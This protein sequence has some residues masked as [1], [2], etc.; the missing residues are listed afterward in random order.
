LLAEGSLRAAKKIGKGAEEAAI[1]VKGFELPMH[2]PRSF[3]SWAVSYPTVPRGGC[4]IAAPTYWLERGVTFPDLVFPEQM[5]SISTDDKGKWTA[6]FQDFCEVLESMVTCKLSI[7]GGIRSNHIVDMISLCTGWDVD[8]KEILQ[9]G[10]RANNIKRLINLKLGFGKKDDTLPE[11][12]RSLSLKEGGTGGYIPDRDMDGMLA[13]YYHF[14][15]WSKDGVPTR[16]KF[17]ELG[18]SDAL[19]GD[20]REFR[21]Y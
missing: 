12:V 15:G 17:D 3:N 13:D 4:H 8:L 20:Y 16:E 1:Q 19:S 7:Y 18:L 14:R 11:R 9:I 10:E 5:D 2:D 6:I 21:Y